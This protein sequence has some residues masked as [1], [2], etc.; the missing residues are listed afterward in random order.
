MV[1]GTVVQHEQ[2]QVLH[3]QEMSHSNTI[4]TQICIKCANFQSTGAGSN[5][6]QNEPN[7]RSVTHLIMENQKMG[8]LSV[9]FIFCVILGSP[10]AASLEGV[11]S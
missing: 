10:N 8:V 4:N 7:F 2:K 11:P 5:L 9:Y 6:D 3:P 1:N